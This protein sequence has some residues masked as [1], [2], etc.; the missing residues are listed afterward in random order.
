[1]LIPFAAPIAPINKI[2][3]ATDFKEPEKDLKIIY[4]LI[5]VDQAVKCRVIS[6]SYHAGGLARWKT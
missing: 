1:M 4:E 5:G 3:F 2:A 6:Y